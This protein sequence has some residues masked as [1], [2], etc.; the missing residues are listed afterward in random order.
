MKRFMCLECLL[1]AGS[2]YI[3]DLHVSD[4][5]QTITEFSEKESNLLFGLD[6]LFSE[7]KWQ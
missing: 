7:Q 6:L 1:L 2:V 5:N 4:E 3:Q